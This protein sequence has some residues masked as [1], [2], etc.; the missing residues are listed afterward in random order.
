M[1][2]KIDFIYGLTLASFDLN[3]NPRGTF[4]VDVPEQISMPVLERYYL[5]LKQI[6]I[7]LC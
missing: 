2:E 4:D 7:T 5:C 1:N 3:I 6:F